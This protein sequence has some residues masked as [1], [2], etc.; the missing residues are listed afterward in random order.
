MLKKT[1]LGTTLSFELPENQYKG[2][3]IDCTYRYIKKLDKY[4]LNMWLRNKSI[5]D[6]FQ[7]CSQEINT[8]Y[9][10]STKEDIQTDIALLIE[11][12]ANSTFFDE[13][14]D[15]FEYASNCFEKGNEFFE[16]ERLNRIGE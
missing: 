8:Q 9:I 5:D 12:A 15:R 3:V 1:Y 4:A 6:R 14:I 11:Q 2:Y 16:D 10:T 7:I 13:F